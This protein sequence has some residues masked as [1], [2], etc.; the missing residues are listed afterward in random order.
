MAN[1]IPPTPVSD[2]VDIERM[3]VG[4]LAA[5]WSHT[6]ELGIVPSA[7]VARAVIPT[8]VP[9]VTLAVRRAPVAIKT[10]WLSLGLTDGKISGL[11]PVV[12]VPIVS[13]AAYLY[14]RI[15]PLILSADSI[16]NV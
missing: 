13:Y 9:R 16:V 12:N 10:D 6:I 11:V 1:M 7:S 5:I 14:V 3:P 8:G 4:P 2:P 15:A